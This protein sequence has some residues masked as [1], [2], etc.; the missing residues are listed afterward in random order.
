MKTLYFDVTRDNTL[1]IGQQYDHKAIQVCFTHLSYNGDIFIR[2]EMGDYSNMIPIPNAI[3]VI[4]K[5]LTDNQ[6]TCRGQLYAQDGDNYIELS[7]VFNFIIKESIGAADPSQYPVDAGVESLYNE[8]LTSISD[9]QNATQIALQNSNITSISVDGVQ[10]SI[11]QNKNVEIDIDTSPAVTN[12]NNQMTT[13]QNNI[14]NLL[15][16]VSNLT[17]SIASEETSPA[18][19]NHEIN[20]Y[21]IFGNQL[22]KTTEAII[23]GESLSVGT[24]ILPISL[25]DI[26]GHGAL[27][28]TA[29]T[30]IQAINEL[31]K[32]E[33]LTSELSWNNTYTDS[34]Q[35]REQKCVKI[36]HSVTI[37]ATFSVKTVLK[38]NQALLS[39]FPRPYGGTIQFVGINITKGT[40]MSMAL[41]S[42]G[43]I[44]RWYGGTNAVGDIIRCSFT[45]ITNE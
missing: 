13:A 2:V 17:A 45:Y 11:D 9:A 5:P 35:Q 36:G 3:W 43:Y 20:E 28:T 8:I 4:G 22:Y 23:S 27:T 14:S 7:R 44:T 37:A 38:D 41:H 39:G 30:I 16:A 42:S 40:P 32:A 34:S 18:T 19:A 24:N 10:Q 6:G 15:T 31:D 29:Q 1:N 12:I 26:I 25:A 21:L 33:A